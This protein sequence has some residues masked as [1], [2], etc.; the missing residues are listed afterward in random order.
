MNINNN[1]KKIRRQIGLTQVQ[2]AKKANIS[3]TSYQRIE[4][5]LQHPSLATALLIAQTLQ[6]TVEELFPL[7]NNS[8]TN[9]E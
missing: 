7:K 3:E 2:V 9:K 8:F 6:T 4:Y 1:L 5:G